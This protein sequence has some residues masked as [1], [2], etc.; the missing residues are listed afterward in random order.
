MPRLLLALTLLTC[1]LAGLAPATLA[2]VSSFD[3]ARTKYCSLGAIKGTYSFTA[4]GY[5]YP[6]P[7]PPDFS[8]PGVNFTNIG[9]LTNDGAGNSS[10]RANSISGAQGAATTSLG[11]PIAGTYTV[12]SNC[13][14]RLIFPNNETYFFVIT[15]YGHELLLISTVP[16]TTITATARRQSAAPP[17]SAPAFA[18]PFPSAYSCS[19]G[20]L[21]G[22]YAL[23]FDAN[24]GR[25][26]PNFPFLSPE[27]ALPA[28]GIATAAVNIQY[29]DGAGNSE[30]L[31]E[32]DSNAGDIFETAPNEL[33]PPT[34][35]TVNS[36]CSGTYLTF[37]DIETTLVVLDGGRELRVMPITPGIS[38]HL[39][40]KKISDARLTP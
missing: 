36:D 2:Q 15:E 1:L 12:N 21:K 35:Y 18:S 28:Q 38:G 24:R 8:A 23:L 31:V 34:R 6:H 4:N 11:A 7:P 29:F 26:F 19:L 25:I 5:L 37:G 20:S 32:V 13:T 10:Y 17:P 22:T 14:G 40:W 33:P 27:F 30:L 39:T 16:G 9:V 3:F